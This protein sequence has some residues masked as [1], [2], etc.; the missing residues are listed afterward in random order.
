MHL[1]QLFVISEPTVTNLNIKFC[2][3][4]TPKAL[5]DAKLHS[6]ESHLF[7]SRT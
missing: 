4:P 7:D 1:L 5:T 2:S 3:L 6:E